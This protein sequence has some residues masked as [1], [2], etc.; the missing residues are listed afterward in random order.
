M[1]LSHSWK[2]RRSPQITRYIIADEQVEECSIH[3]LKPS[4]RRLPYVLRPPRRR[5]VHQTHTI[6]AADEEPAV[7][8]HNHP[9][10][11]R[12]R[13]RYAPPPRLYHSR[14]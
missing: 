11:Q 4:E 13:R 8:E 6:Y 3:I 7:I 10:K 5:H 14:H 1:P 12:R 2:V 9:E